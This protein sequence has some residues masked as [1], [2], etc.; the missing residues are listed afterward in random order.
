MTLAYGV[1]SHSGGMPRVGARIDGGVVDLAAALGDP[2]FDAPSLNGFLAQGRAKW[3]EVNDAVNRRTWDTIPLDRVRPHLP[4]SVGDYVDFYASEHHASNIGRILRPDSPPLAANWK[5]L[6]IAYHGRSGTIILSGTPIARPHGLGRDGAFGPTRR[7]DIEAEV[8]FV[9]GTG[10]MWGHPVRPD[11]IEEHVFGVCL[12]NDWSARDIQAFEYV[13]L[14]PFLGKS[15]ATSI[16]PWIVP[17]S[18]LRLAKITPPAQDPLPA[19][20]LRSEDGGWGLDIRLEIAVNGEVIARPP[21]STMYWTPAQMLAHMTINGASVRTG[22]LFASGTVSGPE[23]GE[24]GCLMELSWNG[25]EPIKLADG[26]TRTFL[27]DGDEVRISAVAPGPAGTL[28]DLGEVTGRILP[29]V[30][31]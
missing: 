7:L 31:L 10:S 11:D 27:E 26:S 20:Y 24:R 21:F 4:F 5:S 1:F 17:L 6:P 3:R 25:Q 14:G 28:I 18:E 9:V 29:P 30:A 8:G 12:V 16:S 22:D 13:P 23:P 15:F 2:V 19:G